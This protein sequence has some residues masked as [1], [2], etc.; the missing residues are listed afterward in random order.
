MPV[1]PF[2]HNV[3]V[4]DFDRLST[5]ARAQYGLVTLEQ[6]LLCGFSRSAIS[7]MIKAAKLERVRLG[8]Y[9]LGGAP[10]I[11]RA[12]ALAAVLSLGDGAVLS[13]RSAA[14]LW[15]LLDHR[16]LTVVDVTAPRECRQPRILCHRRLLTEKDRTVHQGIPVTT[17]AR[18]LVDLAEYY[19]AVRLGLFIDEAL[20][21]GITSLRKLRA[22]VDRLPAKG[23][24]SG[25]RG[26]MS[27]ALADRGAGYR[28]PDSDWEASMDR[29]WDRS[30]LPV[31]RRQYDVRVDGRK[32]RLDRAIPEL[33]IAIEWNGREDH[34]TR[35]RF[36]YD[37]D[38]RSRLQAAGWRVLDFHYRSAP[39]FITRMVLTA[40]EEQRRLFCPPTFEPADGGG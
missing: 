40:C 1:T 36:E 37:C 38:R 9:R 39:E 20:R 4:P 34:G 29:W 5:F 3:F 33:L 28:P 35:S 14:A 32:Y 15:G 17:A 23:R 21:M 13:H 8:V 26:P 2:Q 11:W 10:K 12:T 30:G 7:R 22:E 6:L 19:G 24:G 18:R 27:E 16:L 25:G 31:A